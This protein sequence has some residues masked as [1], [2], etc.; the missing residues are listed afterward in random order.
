MARLVVTRTA[1]TQYT[2]GFLQGVK[3]TVTVD[4][5]EGI[6]PKIFV[7]LQMPGPTDES[8]DTSDREFHNVA[9][10][11]DIEDYPEDTPLIGGNRPY[12]RLNTVELRF[13]S[14]S[15]AEDTWIAMQQDIR[16]LLQAW[17]DS[18]ILG[19]SETVIFGSESS[20]S[21]SSSS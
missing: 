13:R 11:D 15:M 9:S 3:Y 21:S 19:S 8:D 5:A 6:T 14:V 1:S 20:S 18:E 17:E 16:A 7:F 4:A 10:P 2:R 12:F